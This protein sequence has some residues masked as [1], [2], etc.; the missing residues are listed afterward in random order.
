LASL[1]I[2]IIAIGDLAA[3]NN[4]STSDITQDRNA[5]IDLSESDLIEEVMMHPN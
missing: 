3:T 2:E 4:N 5:P 1:F